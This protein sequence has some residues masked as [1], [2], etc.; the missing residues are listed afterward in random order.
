MEQEKWNLKTDLREMIPGFHDLPEY[1]KERVPVFKHELINIKEYEENDFEKYTKLTAM[2]LKAF[3]YAFEEN[4]EV[5]LRVFL[6][7]IK[8]A[9]KEESL[10]TLIYYGEIYLKYIELT[11]S[12]LKEEDIREEIRKLDGKGDVTMGILEQ[13]EERGIKK[14]IQKGIKEGEIKTAKNSLKLGIPLE[15]VA[16]IS[17][18]TLE[19]VKKIKRE[20]EK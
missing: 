18:L 1:F 4:L 2:M 17:E 12:Q 15:Q 11:N 9:E 16:Q 8:E 13:I 14:G 19:E 3:K 5:V 6:L 10:D 20:L 7:A